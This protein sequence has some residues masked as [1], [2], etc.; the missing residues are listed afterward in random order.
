MTH[1][2]I[3]VGGGIGG[4]A[5][6]LRAAQHGLL[7]A[8][9]RGDES[10]AKASRVRYVY[11]VD[12]MIGVH[13]AIVKRKVLERLAGPEHA[14]ARAAL[15]ATHFHIGTQDIV[16]DVVERL[17]VGFAERV[18][19]VDRKAVAARKSGDGFE[20][21]TDDG[22]SVRAP[23]VIL[24]TGVMDRQPAVKLTTKAGK[25]LDE[26]RW[27]YPWANNETLLYC[28]LCE[29]HL[30]RNARVAVFGAS[31]AAAQ[32]AVLLHERYGVEVALLGN[33]APLAAAADT[34]RLME[35]YGIRFH[36]A[37]VVE[38]IDGG[39]KPKGASLRG[40]RLE[41]G[42]TV[43]LRFGM[44]AL[45]LHRVYNDLARQ[46]GADLDDRD[47]GPIE[48]R[49]VLVDDAGSETSVRGFFAVGDMSRRPGDAPSLKQIY[50]AQEYAVRAVQTIDRRRRA[51]R[52]KAILAGEREP[53]RGSP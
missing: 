53:Q 25:V 4:S 27:I 50:T 17:R 18:A 16:D 19:F 45:G 40:F 35:V 3:V 46:L 5:A 29:G 23:A 14:D 26:V 51:A 8:W 44:V 34:R 42:T 21:G 24:A 48:E 6:A 1:D 31:D 22:R 2:V 20:I 47:A 39:E 36:G 38:V 30:V 12:N 33:G 49:H 52:R 9:I 11:N 43:E 28:I 41:D 15:E 32:V 13:D 7:V 37:R 10:T